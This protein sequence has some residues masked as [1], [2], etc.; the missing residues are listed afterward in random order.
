MKGDNHAIQVSQL[1]FYEGGNTLWVHGPDGGTVLR[2]KCTGQVKVN[3]ECENS[4]PHSDMTV[5]GDIE[6]CIPNEQLAT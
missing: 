2:I 1:E 6:I 4:C 3:P 5:R